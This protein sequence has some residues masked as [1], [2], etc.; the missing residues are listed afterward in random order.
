MQNV[1]KGATITIS[2][3]MASNSNAGITTQYVLVGASPSPSSYSQQPLTWKISS[4]SIPTNLIFP[5]PVHY[6]ST[7]LNMSGTI[8]FGAFKRRTGSTITR[9]PQDPLTERAWTVQ[10][11]V[12]STR[13]IHFGEDEWAWDCNTCVETSVDSCPGFWSFTLL[14]ISLQQRNYKA[15]TAPD[16]SHEIV[17]WQQD[18][19]HGW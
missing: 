10:E 7:V 19:F 6:Q 13:T 2:A 11:K 5:I 12:L 18:L 9:F 15:N 3:T 8:Y 16:P 14:E 17:P 4:S 1:Y